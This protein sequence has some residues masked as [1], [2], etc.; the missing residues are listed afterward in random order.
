MSFV[1]RSLCS[2]G[3]PLALLVAG[4]GAP[5]GPP[6]IRTNTTERAPPTITATAV[7]LVA[8]DPSL[9][10]AALEAKREEVLKFL[11][12]RGELTTQDVVV[13]DTARADR[14]I[15]VVLRGDGTYRV[16]AFRAG[17]KAALATNGALARAGSFPLIEPEPRWPL[18]PVFPRSYRRYPGLVDPLNPFDDPFGPG[19]SYYGPYHRDYLHPAPLYPRYYR[20]TPPPVI[21]RPLDPPPIRPRDRGYAPQSPPTPREPPPPPMPRRD[22]PPAVRNDDFPR[23]PR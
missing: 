19:V 3:L 7:L 4:C 14:L 23:P 12:E 11:R 16:T 10:P 5:P 2:L 13:H 18:Q 1:H 17:G 15:R 6:V 8:D 20:P 21:V 22:P 9:A